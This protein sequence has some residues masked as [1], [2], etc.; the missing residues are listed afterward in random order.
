M[1]YCK[2]CLM[3]DTRPGL[4]FDEGVCKAC[5]NF[6]S[7]KNTDW[8]TRFEELEKICDKYRGS[9]GDGYDCAIAVSGGWTPNVN[10][11]SHCGGKLLWDG[12]C[13]FYKPD[14]ENTPIG[15]EGETNMLALGACT[16]VFSN[17]DIQDQVP[18]KIN[19][20]ASRL[21]IKSKRYIET[22]IFSKES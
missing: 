8:N 7:Q 9:N 22:N 2:K 16:G 21:K 1:K 5:I 3:P 20:L 15:K 11:W 4:I 13:G 12:E 10:L 17:Y 19:Q 18:R 14:P 6:E